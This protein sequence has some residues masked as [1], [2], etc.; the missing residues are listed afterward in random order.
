VTAKD[1]EI[2]ALEAKLRECDST[3]ATL[4]G[5]NSSATPPAIMIR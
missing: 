2:A 5:A 4:Y 1:N 3:I